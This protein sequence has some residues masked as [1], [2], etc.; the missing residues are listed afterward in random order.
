MEC[1]G[2]L[3]LAGKSNICHYLHTL[4]DADRWAMLIVRHH[5][6]SPSP[7][8]T[9]PIFAIV[10][11]LQQQSYSFA[12]VFSGLTMKG[13]SSP[14]AGCSVTGDS[15][16]YLLH[17]ILELMQNWSPWSDRFFEREIYWPKHKANQRCYPANW[18]TKD[19]W[20]IVISRF[21]K[22]IRYLRMVIYPTYPKS[23]QLW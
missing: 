23:V 3:N 10:L 22:S 11:T 14:A 16:G 7:P 6:H 5:T 4:H 12:F 2:P 1:Y 18:V 17:F 13:R 19:P 21:S 15:V 8:P 9:P 20:D